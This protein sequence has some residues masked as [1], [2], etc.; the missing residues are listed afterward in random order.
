MDLLKYHVSIQATMKTKL[1][2]LLVLLLSTGPAWAQWTTLGSETIANS[3]TANDQKSPAI[4]MDSSSNYVMAWESF[5][6]DGS[7]YGIYGQ[8]F[9]SDGSTNGGQFLVNT[10][11][12]NDQRF[13]DAAMDADGDF[14]VVWM[15]YTKDGDGWG[16]YG[17]RYDNTGST[18]GGEFKINTTTAGEQKQPKVAMDSLGNFIVVWMDIAP[19]DSSIIMAQ[20]Y[21]NTGST[22]GGEFE[23][24][25]S[26]AAY[27]GYPAVDMDLDGDFVVTWQSVGLDGSGNGIYAQRYDNTATKQGSEFLVNTATSENQQDPA[28]AVDSVGNFI[29]LWS[30]YN[31]D[32]DA[33]GIYAQRWLNTGAKDSLEIRVSST[34]TGAQYDPEV[35]GS[36]SGHF[37]AIWTDYGQDGNYAGTYMKVYG[38]DLDTIESE[39]LVNT[40]TTDFQHGGVIDMWQYCDRWVIGWQDGLLN[41]ASTNDGDDYGVYF[42]RYEHPL[43]DTIEISANRTTVC[44]GDTTFLKLDKLPDNAVILWKPFSLVDDS[45]IAMPKGTF[46]TDTTMTVTVRDGSNGCDTTLTIDIFVNDTT[47]WTGA[48]DSSW[49]DKTNWNPAFVPTQKCHVYVPGT[50]TA[51][52]QPWIDAVDAEAL[53]LTIDVDNGGNITLKSGFGLDVYKEE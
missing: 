29:I 46:T 48:T 49:F 12:A 21:D 28:I 4:A 5:G 10:T 6:T 3:T 2:G 38:S 37:I 41:S 22:V 52:E 32:G 15:D 44:N 26:N 7:G 27:H 18:D 11:T 33:E 34:T 35:A 31:Q 50:G 39:T 25:T 51:P 9:N 13:P 8:R 20:L 1:I 45:S 36:T 43:P 23:V 53:E 30:S 16:V 14:I 40:R 19:D 24:N 42:Q 17:Q 47:F